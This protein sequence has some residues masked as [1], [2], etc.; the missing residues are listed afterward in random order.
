[1][2]EV[3]AGVI[4]AANYTLTAAPNPMN[5]LMLYRNG[6][7]QLLNTHYTLVGATITF[8]LAYAPVLGDWLFCHYRY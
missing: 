1:M 8:A 2:D 3:P 7:Y 6:V 5:S 4:P